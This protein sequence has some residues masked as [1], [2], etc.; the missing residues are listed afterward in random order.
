VPG[1]EGAP[2]W[3][4]RLAW[5][6]NPLSDRAREDQRLL[7]RIRSF[8]IASDGV[9]GSPRIFKD[10]REEGERCGVHRVARIMREHCIRALDVYKRPRYKSGV[11]ALVAPDRLEQQFTVD[12]PDHA[13]VTDITYLRTHEGFLYLAVVLDLYS[14]MVV[15]WSIKASL[16]RDLVLDALVMS[17]W[18]RQPKRP[19]IIH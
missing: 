12:T 19:V 4:L 6:R 5:L 14:R 17:V 16:H 2:K 13:W 18:R 8:Y 3:V 9:Y 15:G 7:E 10:L 1:A 11:P